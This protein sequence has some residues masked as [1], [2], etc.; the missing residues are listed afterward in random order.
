MVRPSP[1]WSF[2]ELEQQDPSR[3]AMLECAPSPKAVADA[4]TDK[5]CAAVITKELRIGLEEASANSN[6]LRAVL[7]FPV[8]ATLFD[9]FLNARTGYRAQFRETW[10][11]GLKYNG[12]IIEAIRQSVLR[13]CARSVEACRLNASFEP[14][15]FTTVNIDAVL[16]SLHAKLSKI[17]FCTS[18][19]EKT[20]TIT[21]L[22]LGLTGSRIL[23]ESGET[24]AAPYREEA[25]AWLDVKGAFVGDNGPYQPKD[26]A[27]RAKRL[28]IAGDA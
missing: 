22:P 23:L 18:L 15:R 5:F 21:A 12:E 13:L 7:Q 10:E 27:A 6:H 4:I 3:A 25:D 26:P 19:I 14:L 2:K 24:W 9:W 11:L 16:Q 20:G 1:A 28:Q 8:G 17:W